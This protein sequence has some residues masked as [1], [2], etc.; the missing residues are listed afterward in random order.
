MI[1][2]HPDTWLANA[3]IIGIVFATA[4]MAAAVT[5]RWNWRAWPLVLLSALAVPLLVSAMAAVLLYQV[6]MLKGA[7]GA[8]VVHFGPLIFIVGLPSALAGLGAALAVRR[9]RVKPDASR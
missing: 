9:V 2:V 5:L 8:F 6:D 3:V 7:A 1:I 4:A